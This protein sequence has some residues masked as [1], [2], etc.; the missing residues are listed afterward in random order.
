MS[1]TSMAAPQVSGM[2]ALVSQYIQDQGLAEKTGL[3]IRSL[4]QS[5]L[6]ST[7]VPIVEDFQGRTNTGARGPAIIRCS[8]RAQVWLTW[9]LQFPQ[10]P[11]S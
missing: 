6:M 9:G 2:A 1:G 4:S 8:G 5:L 10:G 11:T 3:S 7:A